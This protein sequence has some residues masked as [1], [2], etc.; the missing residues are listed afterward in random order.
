MRGQDRNSALADFSEAAQLAVGLPPSAWITAV[1]AAGELAIL[2]WH[3]EDFRSSYEAWARAARILIANKDDSL[4]WK[5][6]LPDFRRLC[7]TYF[8]RGS[9]RG[10]SDWNCVVPASGI[11]LVDLKLW[12]ARIKRR[13]NGCCRLQSPCSLGEW[14][15]IGKL[16]NGLVRLRKLPKI[17]VRMTPGPGASGPLSL[18][19]SYLRS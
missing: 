13:R 15:S 14:E 8:G 9:R 11:L 3:Q 18:S 19:T 10:D 2:L 7:S 16:V 4:D 5:M 6:P 1:R 17:V 12:Q